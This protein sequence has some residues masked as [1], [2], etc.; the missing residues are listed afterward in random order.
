MRLC[1]TTM[2]T[3]ELTVAEQT[4]V[5]KRYGF[6]AIDLRMVERGAGEI[7]VDATAEQLR[8]IRVAAG[9]INSVFCYNKRL[10]SGAEAM[11][12]SIAHHLCIARALEASTIRIFTGELPD[13]EELCLCPILEKALN[14]SDNGVG[15]VL[16]N[17]I[18]IGLT[19]H[20]TVRLCR[21]MG[22]ERV[23]IALSP[24]HAKLI[25]EEIPLEEA[26]PFIKELYI[27]GDGTKNLGRPSPDMLPCYDRIIR[28]LLD[29]EFSG[30]MTFKWGKCW[31]ESLA[32]WETVFPQFVEWISRYETCV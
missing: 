21:A 31:D 22:T 29:R 4:A 1:F 8:E 17:H 26:L 16:Q 19:A 27:D 15:I 6:S 14:A 28:T 9:P 18:N 3:P 13:G 12:D 23:G 7:P 10:E 20:Q 11:A 25:G 30:C 2:G 5:M 32:S 24:D